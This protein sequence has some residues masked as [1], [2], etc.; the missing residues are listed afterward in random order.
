[1]KEKQFNGKIGMTLQDSRLSFVNQPAGKKPNVVYIVLDDVGFAQLGCYGSNIHTPN[2]DKLAGSGLRYN[3][4]H[5]T[6]ICS[7]TRSALLTGANHHTVGIG[8]VTDT[9]TGFPNDQGW[10]KPEYATLAEI[11]QEHD[12]TNF[13][14]GK[15]HLLPLDR[16][17]E[18]GPHQNW[19]LQKG[20]DKFYGFMEGFTD[21]FHP[22]LVKDNSIIQQP[23]ASE[24]GYHL[25]EDLSEQAIHY[26]Y[27]HTT[28]YPEK[29]F[30]LYLAYGAAHSPHQ[31]PKEYIDKYKGKFDEGWDVIRQKW[32]DNQKKLG[33]IPE[34]TVLTPRNRLVKAW[35]ELSDDERKVYA[36]YMEVF[37]GFLEH[38]DA[39]IGKV[40]DFLEETGQR[41]NTIIVL[42]SDNGTSAEGGQEG[43][44]VHEKSLDILKTGTEVK[45]ALEHLDEIGTEYSS[46]HYPLGWAN[47][48]NTPFQWYKSWTHA[49]GVKDPLIISY[50][51]Y[52]E[53]QGGIRT[54]YHHVSDITP[55]ILDLLDIEKP[56]M[57]KGISQEPFQGISMK[58]SLNGENEPT[59]KH[60]QYYEMVGN[61][62]L[63]K[64][65]W[66]V[67]ANH[68]QG[69]DYMDDVWELYHTDE[70]YSEARDIAKEH[71][72]KVK[73][74]VASWFAEAG[75]NG[76][77]PL[78]R[79]SHFD[80]THSK[81]VPQIDYFLK[82]QV[83]TYKNIREPFRISSRMLAFNQRNNRI[84]VEIEHQAGQEGILYQ[85][86]NRFGGYMLFI[87]DNKLHYT[88]NFHLEEFYRAISGELPD[89]KLKIYVDTVL[90]PDGGKAIIRVNGKEVA[91][92]DI[93]HFAF[94]CIFKTS[95]KDGM[96]TS[97]DPE[98]KLPFEYSGKMDSIEFRAAPQVVTSKELLDEFFRID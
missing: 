76:V 92:T 89:G 16:T 8:N 30:F 40:I 81:K 51:D 50:P 77:F 10:L 2:I 79:G 69:K 49:G 11:L 18:Q 14:V 13:A 54:Q 83:F 96:L 42:L 53:K 88:Y 28:A 94:M 48:G 98:I 52:I 7:A 84:T 82:E 91:Q 45:V 19:P 32:F 80:T 85:A 3:N 12:Y 15:W 57:I 35:D 24:D 47:A 26:I 23:K 90:T 1:M 29:P 71:P 66:K 55:T 87:K 73:E 31:A 75:K 64:D 41:E 58:Y 65:G 46:P 72:E 60:I 70:D 63:W 37:A 21:Q 39:Q 36:R 56:K 61:R 38:T 20:F 86:G 68:F 67:I 97:V 59:K 9:C 27:Q 33:I 5:T 93:S 4:F 34:D 78:G 62:A 43:H 95:F 44:F 25:S 6:A 17:E 74:L 22:D